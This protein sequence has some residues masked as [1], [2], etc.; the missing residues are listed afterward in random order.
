MLTQSPFL[1]QCFVYGDSLQS[2]LVAIVVPNVEH[3]EPWAK[4]QNITA[5]SYAE[6]CS[7][8]EVNAAILKEMTE[9]GKKASLKG[10]N[11]LHVQTKYQ[12][13]ELYMIYE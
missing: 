12:M 9:V 2:V 4:S 11:Y 3:L 5:S 6:L 7:K 8:P 13:L 1:A 10:K